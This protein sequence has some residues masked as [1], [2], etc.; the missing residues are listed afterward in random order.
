MQELQLVARLRRTHVWLGL[1]NLKSSNAPLRLDEWWAK[2]A[3]FRSRPD[4]GRSSALGREL[5]LQLRR[6][7]LW[8]VFVFSG[9]S[10]GGV[11]GVER[12]RA[13]PPPPAVFG[14]LGDHSCASARAAGE[15]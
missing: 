13:L 14:C 11:G 5:V 12:G 9:V 2:R 3:F 4:Y 15:E 10:G 7:E 6:G 8:R 1:D